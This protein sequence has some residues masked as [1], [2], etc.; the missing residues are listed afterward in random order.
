[1]SKLTRG[2]MKRIMYV[3]SDE[4]LLAEF[5]KYA[6]LYNFDYAAT[7]IDDFQFRYLSDN[8]IQIVIIDIDDTETNI[9][10]W[11]IDLKFKYNATVIFL[12]SESN[13]FER[14]RWLSLGI[15][16]YIIKPF[17]M[18]EIIIKTR[19]ILIANTN[20]V[21]YDGEMVIDVIARS[22]K[23]NGY[24]QKLTP[25]VFDLLIYFL[26]NEGKVLSREQI[27]R[28]V[29]NIDHYLS[30]RNIDALVKNL[31]KMIPENRIKTV[32]GKGYCYERK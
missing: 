29:L 27:M 15:N 1:M 5:E 2:M 22:I 25:K 20:T 28:N 32:R 4:K 23:Y 18:E 12:S 11:V 8:P 6:L 30:D 24:E 26:E 21:I 31:R 9:Y 16:D 3:G 13:R 7:T 17:C 10:Q 19:N 14:A